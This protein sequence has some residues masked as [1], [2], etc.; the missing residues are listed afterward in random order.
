MPRNDPVCSLCRTTIHGDGGESY[1]RGCSANIC[2]ACDIST[3]EENPHEP[4]QHREPKKSSDEDW[5]QE[6]ERDDGIDWDFVL[7]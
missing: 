7:E 5:E 1:C 2:F 4:T 6:T 3:P